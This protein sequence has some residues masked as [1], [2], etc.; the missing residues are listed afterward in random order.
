[1]WST[2]FKP[3]NEKSAQ[4]PFYFIKMFAISVNLK[5][6]KNADHI[7]ESFLFMKHFCHLSNIGNEERFSSCLSIF[8]FIGAP[9]TS[10]QS[11]SDLSMD[12][13]PSLYLW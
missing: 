2:I 8:I 9:I 4:I 3:S 6:M 13:S 5:N 1:M 11:C 10:P 12:L 7:L